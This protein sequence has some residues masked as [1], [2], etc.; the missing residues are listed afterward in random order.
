MALGQ[1]FQGIGNFANNLSDAM[2]NAQLG[3]LR[4]DDPAAYEAIAQERALGNLRQQELEER[5]QERAR[6]IQMQKRLQDALAN[7][8]VL[9]SLSKTLNL[10]PELLAGVTSIDELGML[11][12]IGLGSEA[13]SPVREYKYYESLSPAAQ[14][15]YLK[16]KR[17][18]QVLNLG[19]SFGALDPSTGQITNTYEKSVPPEMEP[20][21]VAARKEAELNATQASDLVKKAKSSETSL[22]ILDKAEMLLPKATGSGLGAI[23]AAGK[24]F[25]GV[26][27]EESQANAQLETLSGWLVSNVPRMEGPQ[28]NF[29]VENYLEMAANVGDKS[30]PIQDRLAALQ[31][32][33]ALHEK[34]AAFNDTT[35]EQIDDSGFEPTT[36]GTDDSALPDVNGMEA[37]GGWTEDKEKRYQELLKKRGQ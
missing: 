8:N 31:G 16:V 5:R 19:G 3:A 9:G 37:Q 7:Q 17:A 4:F 36:T 11:G 21:A 12:R 26:S 34:Y 23:G 2:Y 6:Q 29:D 10:P 25:V 30:I 35:T 13:P 24:Q 14:A 1:V 33:R 18:Q 22:D 27:D 28:S 15:D 32:L 20:E